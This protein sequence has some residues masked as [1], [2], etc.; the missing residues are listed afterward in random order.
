MSIESFY[1]V[2]F[3]SRRRRRAAR[4]QAAMRE[5]M[6]VEGSGTLAKARARSAWKSAGAPG[7]GALGS[8]VL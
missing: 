8:A 2:D 3:V 5:S 6:E 1:I 4:P 7:I